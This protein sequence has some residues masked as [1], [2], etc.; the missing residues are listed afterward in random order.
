[1]KDGYIA[2][3]D[4]IGSPLEEDLK[5]LRHSGLGQRLATDQLDDLAGL[6]I[7]PDEIAALQSLLARVD[8]GS[9]GND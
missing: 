2:R 6:N 4:L 9:D 5:V 7:Q 1:M 3:E 8:G